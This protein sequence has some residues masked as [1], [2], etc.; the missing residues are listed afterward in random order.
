MLGTGTQY[1]VHNPRPHEA[2]LLHPT[3]AC[4]RAALCVEGFR[5]IPLHNRAA[6]CVEGFRLIPLHNRV[7]LCVEGGL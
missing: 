6:L 4:N 3:V 1:K 2:A 7:A 5:L